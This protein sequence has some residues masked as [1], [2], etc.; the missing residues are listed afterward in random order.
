MDG[1]ACTAA[2]EKTQNCSQMQSQGTFFK[3]FKGIYPQPPNFFLLPPP[4]MQYKEILLNALPSIDFLY[5][6]IW[7]A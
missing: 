3:I 5:L 4:L 1:L 7:I 6:L 2:A